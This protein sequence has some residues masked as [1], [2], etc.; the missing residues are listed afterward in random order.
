MPAPASPSSFFNGAAA[1][2]RP[3]LLCVALANFFFL[4][5]SLMKARASSSDAQGPPETA[6]FD[7][8]SL[9]TFSRMRMAL[10]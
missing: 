6:Y 8:R 9:I 10:S 2:S 1:V 5:S 7:P 3:Q 4:H